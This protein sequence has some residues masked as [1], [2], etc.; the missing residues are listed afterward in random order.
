MMHTIT[1]KFRQNPLLLLTIALILACTQKPALAQSN[2]PDETYSMYRISLT[3]KDIT[4]LI[5]TVVGDEAQP[6]AILTRSLYDGYVNAWDSIASQARQDLKN[7]SLQSSG[8]GADYYR[9]TIQPMIAEVQAKWVVDARQLEDQF[10]GDVKAILNENEQARWP[11]FEQARRRTVLLR[12]Y[13]RIAGEGVDLINLA[14]TLHFPDEVMGTLQ[15]TLADYAS[16]LDKEILY[17]QK[18]MDDAKKKMEEIANKQSK[19][20][21]ESVYAGILFAHKKIRK[22]NEDYAEQIEQLLPD[23]L[24]A[25]FKQKFDQTRFPRLLALTQADRYISR[26]RR[27]E[28]LTDLQKERIEERWSIYE[29]DLEP[30]IAQL[31]QGQRKRD[32]EVPYQYRSAAGRNGTGT[33][34]GQASNL[35]KQERDLWKKRKDLETKLIDDVFM[36]LNDE[37]REQAP[38]S[39]SS[40]QPG[41]FP[42]GPLEHDLHDGEDGG[43]VSRFQL[44]DFRFQ[45]S[46]FS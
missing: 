11:L 21:K 16:E 36:M 26:V 6:A 37:Q 33:A 9:T 17:R 4:V 31:I 15:P 1:H 39:S 30:I 28:T 24:A 10:L 44:T 34:A 22:T 35:V 42:S 14:N 18:V 5:R 29:R 19:V 46:D 25:A 40:M 8:K 45:L 43:L 32:E 7:I 38:K 2:L 20:S 12:R 3:N 23:D 13:S 41:G 27:L